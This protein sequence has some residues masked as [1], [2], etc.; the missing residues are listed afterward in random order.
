MRENDP[1]TPSPDV[2]TASHRAAPRPVFVDERGRRARWLS[3]TGALL[4]GIMVLYLAAMGASITGASWVPQ[5]SLPVVGAVVPGTHSRA[6]LGLPATTSPARSVI[7]PG[8]PT[9]PPATG[10]GPVADTPN[11]TDQAQLHP[12][13][14]VQASPAAAPSA[15]SAAA[16]SVSAAQ[17]PSANPPPSASATTVAPVPATTPSGKTP[18]G[19]VSNTTR[20]THTTPGVTAPGRIKH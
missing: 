14:Q 9:A 11:A 20:T 19:Q 18:P 12:T 8:G 6:K 1:V 16:T 10:T 2:I 3:R 17:A 4:A 5:L 13:A 15:S 7:A